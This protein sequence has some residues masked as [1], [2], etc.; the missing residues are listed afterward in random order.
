MQLFVL[1]G[2]GRVVVEF[3]ED[4]G[5]FRLDRSNEEQVRAII[6]LEAALKRLKASRNDKG[7]K[8]V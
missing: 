4:S 1:N 6:F 5:D 7:L 2:N 8:N 3:S